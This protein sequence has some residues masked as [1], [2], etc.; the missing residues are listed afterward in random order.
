MSESPFRRVA[1]VSSR[2]ARQSSLLIAA[3]VATI[4]DLIAWQVTSTHPAL[5]A[6]MLRPGEVV[7][8]TITS[9]VSVGDRVDVFLAA[10]LFTWLLLFIT[11]ALSLRAYSA[12]HLP[13]GA[14]SSSIVKRSK[15]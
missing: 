6:A 11:V 12:L 9:F 7:A 1:M 2:P 3:G 13:N 8:N 10:L 15:P 14:T 5:M 4:W